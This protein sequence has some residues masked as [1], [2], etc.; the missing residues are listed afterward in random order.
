MKEYLYLPF[1]RC[2][3]CKFLDESCQR[4]YNKCHI[5]GSCPAFDIGIVVENSVTDLANQYRQ[6]TKSQ[7]LS[8]LSSILETVKKNGKAFEYKFKQEIK[9]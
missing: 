7:N 4:G 9:K 6:A 1:S 8:L 5:K 3:N 2:K